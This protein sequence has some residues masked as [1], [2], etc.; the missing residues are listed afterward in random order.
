M[1][2]YGQPI[3]ELPGHIDDVCRAMFGGMI[4]KR[5]MRI[6][7]VE[8]TEGYAR[9]LK[10]MLEKQYPK[11]EITVWRTYTFCHSDKI[12]E[13]Q[14]RNSIGV[15]KTLMEYP[16]SLF[17]EKTPL[18]I[19]QVIQAIKCPNCGAPEISDEG[20][21]LYCESRLIIGGNHG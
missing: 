13:V 6:N 16:I 1:W 12:L 10:E 14:I 7:A 20:I 21:C 17:Q 4:E 15:W 11:V 18:E 3:K 5:Q 9:K 2:K 8:A 19:T